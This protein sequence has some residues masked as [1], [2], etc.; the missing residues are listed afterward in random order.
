[1]W[2]VLFQP[3]LKGEVGDASASPQGTNTS[4]SPGVWGRQ[5]HFTGHAHTTFWVFN[6]N[7]PFFLCLNTS[8]I[9]TSYQ[10]D[11]SIHLISRAFVVYWNLSGIMTMGLIIWIACGLVDSDFT[12]D[13]SLCHYSIQ[14]VVKCNHCLHD[15]IETLFIY[16]SLRKFSKMLCNDLL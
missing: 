3:S 8:F 11:N 15:F 1:M 14:K 2:F 6:S 13:D 9:F 4:S 16:K 5:A 12:N 10:Q 7:P